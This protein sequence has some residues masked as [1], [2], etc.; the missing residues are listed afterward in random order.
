MYFVITEH[1]LLSEISSGFE[2]ENISLILNSQRFFI[3]NVLLNT[4]F[5]CCFLILIGDSGRVSFGRL[6]S[7]PLQVGSLK[8]IYM[9]FC[10]NMLL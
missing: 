6:S 10:D 8:N 4:P 3:I 7:P 5:K 1:Y 2:L 9:V